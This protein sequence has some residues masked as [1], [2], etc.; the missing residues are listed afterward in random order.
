MAELKERVSKIEKNMVTKSDL[1]EMVAELR[2][3]R[4]EQVVGAEQVR[5]VTDENRNHERRLRVLEKK[6]GIATPSFS[7]A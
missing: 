5:R 2:A 3:S 1:S 6:A 7:L 4:E